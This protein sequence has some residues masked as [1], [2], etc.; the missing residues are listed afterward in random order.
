MRNPK[1]SVV[2]SVRNEADTVT[3]AIGSILSQDF[4]DFEFIIVDDGSK[5]KTPLMLSLA[6]RDDSRISIIQQDALGLAEALNVGIGA[7][8]A[9]L[10]ARMDADDI[11]NP[12]RLSRQIHFLHN[13]SHIHVLGSQMILKESLAPLGKTSFPLSNYLIRKQLTYRNPIGH[14]TVLMRRSAIEAVGGYQSFPLGQDY[15]L[16]LRLSDAGYR[17]ANLGEVLLE[18]RLSRDAG[19]PVDCQRETQK[20]LWTLVIQ[21]QGQ[22]RGNASQSGTLLSEEPDGN[23]ARLAFGNAQL[24]H[25]N[26]QPLLP[27]EMQLR[28]D[29]VLRLS[30]VSSHLN[31]LLG[32]FWPASLGPRHHRQQLSLGFG[33]LL[34]TNL[35][36]RIWFAALVCA[37]LGFALSPTI[38]AVRAWSSILWPR[39]AHVADLT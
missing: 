18:Y 35:S 31:L 24:S 16:W 6:A 3:T 37:L 7:S 28:A 12:Q 15:D 32:N 34:A 19:H 25:E 33:D 10:I 26:L 29:I 27:R 1:V 9:P 23:L 17:F 13:N 4:W 14:P 22:L 36:R 2:M 39:K 11:A 30:P 8:S 20:K 38:F 5:D 21:R